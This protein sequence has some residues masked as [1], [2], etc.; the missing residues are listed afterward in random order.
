MYFES[1]YDRFRPEVK[2]RWRELPGPASGTWYDLGAH[3]ADQALQLFGVPDSVYGDLAMQRPGAKTVDY[4][5]V[6]LCYGK[7]RVVL[8]G[9]SLVV[10]NTPRFFV[11][12]TRGSYVKHGIDTQESALKAGKSPAS[13]D[14]GK[15]PL[16]GILFMEQD[17][18]M[19]SSSIPNLPGNYLGYYEALRDAILSKGAN[20]VPAEQ[21]LQVMKVLDTAERSSEQGRDISYNDRLGPSASRKNR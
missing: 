9:G 15:D 14:W 5:H 4:F 17:G 7:R 13:S 18:K 19:R 3:L 20:P 8:H 21:A 11:H 16:E 2:K 6:L 12:G 1:R 10:A